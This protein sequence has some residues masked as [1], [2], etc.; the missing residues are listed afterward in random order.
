MITKQEM[1]EQ[2]KCYCKELRL[3][4]IRQNFE[5]DTL[6]ANKKNH[7]Y[8]EFLYYLLQKE[9]DLRRENGKKTGFAWQVS[10]QKNIWRI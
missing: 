4:A 8:E 10:L 6:E 5:E 7:A 3:S 1:N 2:I 9:A